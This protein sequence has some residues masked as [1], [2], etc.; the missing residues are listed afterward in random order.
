ME[1]VGFLESVTFWNLFY[2]K[3]FIIGMILFLVVLIT[4]SKKV[5]RKLKVLAILVYIFVTFSLMNHSFVGVFWGALEPMGRSLG[6]FLGD[7][8]GGLH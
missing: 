4:T 1:N 8:F 7:L 6:T 2:L 5:K 3:A